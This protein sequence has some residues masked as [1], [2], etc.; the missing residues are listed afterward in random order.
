MT[1][2][3]Q[4]TGFGADSPTLPAGWTASGSTGSTVTI[5]GTRIAFHTGAVGARSDTAR[6]ILDDPTVNAQ[7]DLSVLVQFDWS[8]TTPLQDEQFAIFLRAANDFANGVSPSSYVRT[9]CDTAGNMTLSHR[10]ASG[11]N[12]DIVDDTGTVTSPFVT[13]WSSWAY[14][15]V[16]GNDYRAKWWPNTISQP[17]TGGPDNDGWLLK[18]TMATDIVSGGGRFAARLLGAQAAGV[19]AYLGM[20]NDLIETVDF[21]TNPQ[22]GGGTITGGRFPYRGRSRRR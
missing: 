17:L 4:D 6:V 18:G 10:L 14:L 16:D 12:V 22:I 5:S 19:N 15:Q 9:T 13:G 2:L 1:T 8:A 7:A 3:H 20:R 21:S 11:T